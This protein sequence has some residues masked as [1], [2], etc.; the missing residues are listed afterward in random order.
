MPLNPACDPVRRTQ[1]RRTSRITQMG[2]SQTGDCRGSGVLPGLATQKL[3]RVPDLRSLLAR[4]E[5]SRPV[6][7][8][9]GS[10]WSHRS[11]RFLGSLK[12]ISPR[13]GKPGGG[14]APP[15]LRGHR[16][17]K[18]PRH[19]CS[20][21]ISIGHCRPQTYRLR[22]PHKSTGPG[23]SRPGPY[24]CLVDKPRRTDD[25]NEGH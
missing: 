25:G 14:L 18:L 21:L 4:S 22:S 12:G 1:R 17:A 9:P 8:R 13:G 16:G 10:G 11:R 23:D 6:P 20:E 3:K 7:S 2:F 15:A 5:T 19:C 24:I